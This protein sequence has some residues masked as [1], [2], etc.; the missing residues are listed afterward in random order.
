M[1]SIIKLILVLFLVVFINGCQ[2]ESAETVKKSETVK[3]KETEVINGYVLPPEPDETLNNSTLLGI[4]SND[5]GVRDDVERK[6]IE[7]Y[8]E[9]IKIEL[10]MATAK[11]G[12]EILENPVGLAKEHSDKMDRLDDCGSYLED[13]N[14]SY[15]GLE[16]IR[17]YE[18]NIYNT[19]TRVRAYLDYNLALSGR[20]YGSSPSDWV[21]ESCDF[22]VKSMLEARK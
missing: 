8:R 16:S 7:T 10:M 21:A 15:D 5:N 22:D 1:R 2:E 6:I 13:Q 4:D 9:P 3:E 11:V 18:K 12:Q 20:V 19:K 14:I 17:F